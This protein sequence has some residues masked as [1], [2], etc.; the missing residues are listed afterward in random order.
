MTPWQADCIDLFGR[1]HH[2]TCHH[3]I[4][5]HVCRD[6]YLTGTSLKASEV[7][8]Y[9]VQAID[10]EEVRD[11]PEEALSKELLGQVGWLVGL[12]FG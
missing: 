2:V 10:M 4:K 11:T 1:T 9:Q 3:V 6:S 5:P 8:L 7:K 12:Q